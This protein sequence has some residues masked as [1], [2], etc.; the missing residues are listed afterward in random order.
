MNTKVRPALSRL[1][2]EAAS[3]HAETDAV[4]ERAIALRESLYRLFAAIVRGQSPSPQDLDELNVILPEALA[5]LR[6]VAG[7]EGYT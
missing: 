1:L 5:R 6:I 3:R 7:A 4:L 2:Q